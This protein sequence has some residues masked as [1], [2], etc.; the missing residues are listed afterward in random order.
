MAFASR[1]HSADSDIVLN[2]NGTLRRTGFVNGN[3]PLFEPRKKDSEENL[4]VMSASGAERRELRETE[5]AA[6][7]S[8]K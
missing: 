1:H 2:D 4:Q 8:E 3:I 5:Q 7:M 6:E